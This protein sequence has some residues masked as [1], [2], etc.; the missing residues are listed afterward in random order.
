[1]GT[2][3]ADSGSFPVMR[4]Q[5][6]FDVALLRL[7]ARNMPLAY[8]VLAARKMTRNRPAKSC[9]PSND[10]AP[11][12]PPRPAVPENTAICVMQWLA[13]LGNLSK[14]ANFPLFSRFRDFGSLSLDMT[15]SKNIGD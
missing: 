12:L 11:H 8:C 14:S 15:A 6:A 9:K 10:L 5:L 2:G 1:M 7:H 3:L 4:R 13:A